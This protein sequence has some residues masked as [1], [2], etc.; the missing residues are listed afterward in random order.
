MIDFEKPDIRFLA[1]IWCWAYFFQFDNFGNN[2]K[3]MKVSWYGVV[4]AIEDFIEI[5]KN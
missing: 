5:D 4:V 3:P 1:E 2:L